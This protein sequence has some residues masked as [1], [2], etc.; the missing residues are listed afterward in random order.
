MTNTWLLV[1]VSTQSLNQR[2]LL[3]HLLSVKKVTFT[4]WLPIADLTLRTP[5]KSFMA[6][7]EGAI[8]NLSAQLAGMATKTY[9][10]VRP[11]PHGSG[12]LP[13]F[14]RKHSSTTTIQEASMHILVSMHTVTSMPSNITKR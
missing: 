14:G 11:K 13:P 10:S 3:Q 8:P 2:V 4:V 9:L 1:N 12:T 5:G 6:L 7:S